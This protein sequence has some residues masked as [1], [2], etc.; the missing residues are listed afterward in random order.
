MPAPRGA[1]IAG[2]LVRGGSPGGVEC[3]LGVHRDKVFG[4]VAMFGL[5]GIFVEALRDVAL[6]RCPFGEDAAEQMIRAVRGAKLLLGARGRPPADMRALAAMLARLSVFAHAAGPRL[7]AVELN[8]VVALAEGEGAS[9]LDALIEIA[10][11]PSETPI[12]GRVPKTP[13]E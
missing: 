12:A 10:P 5:G 1:R 11:D 3:I 4:P 8:P 6:R 2:V 13:R 9:A 7:A